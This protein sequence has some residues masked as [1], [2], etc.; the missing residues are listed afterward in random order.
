MNCSA[1]DSKCCWP[2]KRRRRAR[3]PV[4]WQLASQQRLQLD[5]GQLVAHVPA[6][7][8]GFTVATPTAEVV[9]L[10]TEFGVHVDAQ[11]QTNVQVFEGAVEFSLSTPASAKPAS[12]P[13][14]VRGAW[15]RG[16]RRGPSARHTP[17]NP[18]GC[19]GKF[20]R[21][22]ARAKDSLREVPIDLK[23]AV[24]TQSSKFAGEGSFSSPDAAIDGDRKTFSHTATE[25]VDGSW[26]QLDFGLVRGRCPP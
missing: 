19:A 24:A 26:W 13:A 18:P 22:V 8:I 2:R 11:G 10:G 25:D 3:G 23:G 15:R 6:R 9:D 20:A 5:S 16:R 14:T 17:W 12:G 21:R 4:S 7:A 1:A